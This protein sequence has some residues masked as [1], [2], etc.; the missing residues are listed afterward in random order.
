MVR[1]TRPAQAQT[2]KQT[3]HQVKTAE[4]R[5][6]SASTAYVSRI[7]GRCGA[8]PNFTWNNVTTS[9]VH[10]GKNKAKP[11]C[12]AAH[13]WCCSIQGQGLLAHA[14]QLPDVGSRNI[15]HLHLGARLAEAVRGL[16]PARQKIAPQEQPHVS[17]AYRQSIPPHS[18]TW[19]MP[20]KKKAE[21]TF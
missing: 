1:R 8:D 21:F 19:S 20:C 11:A 2:C 12:K 17:Q 9:V 16:R 18:T 13:V 10:H 7:A 5:V 14:V 6:C 3:V 4:T 15:I